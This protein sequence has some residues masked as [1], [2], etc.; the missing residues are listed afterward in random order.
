M[1]TAQQS[2]DYSADCLTLG[3][4]PNLSVQRGTVLR[5]M[6]RS[7]IALANQKDRYDAIVIGEDK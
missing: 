5:A 4:K 1:I 7:W 2:R 6:S 3:T